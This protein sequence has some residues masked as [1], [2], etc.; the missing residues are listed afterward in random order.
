MAADG[1]AFVA[2]AVKAAIAAKAPRRTVQGVA[3]AVAGVFAHAALAH[4]APK[5]AAQARDAAQHVPQ[6]D[7]TGA[8]PATL[9]EALR[10]ARR[11]QRALKREKRRAAKQEDHTRATPTETEPEVATTAAPTGGPLARPQPPPGQPTELVSS[12]VPSTASQRSSSW[13]PF[14]DAGHDTATPAIASGSQVIPPAP[15]PA[16][17]GPP[18]ERSPRRLGAG[19]TSRRRH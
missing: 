19:S 4:A 18:R 1:P 15:S 13:D 17:P 10:H 14:G 5:P 3:A 16:L 11:A 7:S 9:V 12:R 2:A 6:V 8:E